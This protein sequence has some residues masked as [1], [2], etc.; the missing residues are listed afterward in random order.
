[1]GVAKLILILLVFVPAVFSQKEETITVKVYFHP[2]KLDPEWMD[3]NKVQAV[4]RTIPRTAAV[5]TAALEELFKGP[6][7]EE[8]KEYTGFGSPD[9]T[10]I[11]KNVNVKNGVA[12]VNFT[13]RLFEQMGTASTSC[14]GGF[15]SMIEATLKQFPT[16]KKVVYAV[17]GNTNDFY[18]WA[19]V[20]ECPFSK[21]LCSASN[22]RYN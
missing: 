13:D 20:G 21:K 9:T 11:L 1:M 2:D 14:G 8:K 12:Y 16:I 3:C 22:F 10:G 18:E 4:T 17:E 7:P 6:T 5:A 15:F 19:Q